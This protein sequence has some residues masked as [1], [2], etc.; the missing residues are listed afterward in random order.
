MLLAVACLG[1][2]GSAYADRAMD[3]LRKS[4]AADGQVAYWAKIEI[5]VHGQG[6][7]KQ[8]VRQE[9]LRAPGNRYRIEVTNS[10]NGNPPVIVSNGHTEWEFRPG[11]SV[12]YQRPLAPIKEIQRKKLNALQA[13][14]DTLHAAYVGEDEVAGRM[15]YV[16]VVKPPDGQRVRKKVWV[17]AQRF[18]ELRGERYDQSGRLITTWSAMQISFDV[19][20]GADD[21]EYRPP[22]R[23]QVKRLERAERTTLAAAEKTV[24]FRAVLPSYLPPGFALDKSQV[25][26]ARLG[27][28]TALWLEFFDGVDTFSLFECPRLRKPPPEAKNAL[29]WEARGLS[30]LLIGRL[31]PEQRSK[32]Q[33]STLD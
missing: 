23:T 19:A 32:V 6:K 18:I 27:G 4:I 7:S 16:V 1:P 28:R 10:G 8:V 13:V 12:V 30:F 11:R 33:R 3:I 2:L 22:A 25:G 29:Y 21:F 31:S 24:G 9:V 5:V 17:D 26:I 20:P 14:E 15:C